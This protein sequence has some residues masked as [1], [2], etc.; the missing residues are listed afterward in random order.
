MERLGND[1]RQVIPGLSSRNLVQIHEHGDERRLT[2]CGQERLDLVLDGLNAALYLPTHTHLCHTVDLCLREVLPDGSQLIPDLRFIFLPGHIHEGCQVRQADRL[3]AVGVTGNLSDDLRGDIAGSRKAV[4]LL[5]Q[6][7]SDDR[8]VLQHVLQIHQLTVGDRPGHIPHVMDVDNA[9]IVGLDHVLREDVSPADI[10]GYFACQVIPH[11]AV[12]DRVLI[13][14]L[15]F[16]NLTVVPEQC[17]DLRIRAVLF[18]KQL[19]AQPI[20]TVVKRMT[21]KTGIRKAGDNHILHF[22]NLDGSTK[23]LTL[24]HNHIRNSGDILCRHARS[25]SF[26]TA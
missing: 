22:L 10:L 25:N 26:L 21:D 6:S 20:I 5:D 17:Q 9:L 23:A 14:V 2:V 16:G 8:P 13:G 4:R 12:D 11:R 3:S 18:P 1:K 15:L 24:S 19:M 7:V